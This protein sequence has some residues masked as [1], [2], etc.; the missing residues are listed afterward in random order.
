[1][2]ELIGQNRADVRAPPLASDNR[3]YRCAEWGTIPPLDRAKRWSS[4]VT[5]RDPS[6]VDLVQYDLKV[7]E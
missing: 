4:E 1:M 2:E 7:T 5:D 3:T 6:F